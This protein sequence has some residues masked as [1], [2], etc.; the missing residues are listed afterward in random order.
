VVVALRGAQLYGF[1]DGTSIASAKQF[2]AKVDSDTEDIP[3]PAFVM[4][5]AQEQHVLSYLLSSV[6]HDIIV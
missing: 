4:W 1:L 6:S 2:K 5:K 3:N